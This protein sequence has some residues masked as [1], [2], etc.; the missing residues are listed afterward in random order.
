M[1]STQ[2]RVHQGVYVIHPRHISGKD[3]LI[4]EELLRKITS[5]GINIKGPPR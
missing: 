4:Q 5:I 3:S 2:P 1:S